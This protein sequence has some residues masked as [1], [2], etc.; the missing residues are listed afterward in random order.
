MKK[1]P[2]KNIPIIINKEKMSPMMAR[3]WNSVAEKYKDIDVIDPWRFSL[4]ELREKYPQ[5]IGK[6]IYRASTG[7][8]WG[9]SKQIRIL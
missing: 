5:F 1:S 2:E 6:K 7:G 3:Y 4:K 9:K 8:R